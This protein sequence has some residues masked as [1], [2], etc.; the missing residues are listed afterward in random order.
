MSTRCWT[1]R[2][3]VVMWSIL[4]FLAVTSSAATAFA[5]NPTAEEMEAFEGHIE[6]GGKLLDDEEF[7]AA[8]EELNLARQIVDHPRIAIRVA[9]AYGDWGRCSLAEEEFQ[10]VLDSEEVDD[11]TIEIAKERMARLEDCVAMAHLSVSCTPGEARLFV[12][13]DDGEEQVDCPFDGDVVAGTWKARA[14][15]PDHEEIA[16]TIELQ[17]GEDRQVQLVLEKSLDIDV[18]QKGGAD[19]MSLA[20]YGAMGTGAALLVGGG[21]LDRRAGQ[22][23]TEMAEA[24]DEGD[25]S[26][27]EQLESDARSARITNIALYA[28]GLTLIAGGVAL[29]FVGGGES[30]MTE[31]PGFSLQLAPGGIS[32]RIRW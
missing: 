30:E 11:D 31:E 26:R 3:S 32:T 20:A 23:V 15:A 27:V 25:L 6:R 13:G 22:R 16:K 10:L 18:A 21:L 8:I 14:T 24:R 9:E 5:Q 4:G 12:E 17:E 29:Y 1:C 7:E 19:W 28:G 2:S